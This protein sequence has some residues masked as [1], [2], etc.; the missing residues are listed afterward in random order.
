MT[1]YIDV[2]DEYGSRT[3]EVLL[4]K[5]IH[6]LGK[7]H[8]AVH[9]YLFDMQDNILLQR[10]TEQA[11]HYP[12]EMS[13]SLTGHIRSGEG[14]FAALKRELKEELNLDIQVLDIQFMFSFR[15]D[16]ILSANYIDKQFNDIYFC[17]NDF[18]LED[19]KFNSQEVSSLEL[20]PFT[21]FT[22][23]IQ[24]KDLPYKKAIED[25]LYFLN[26]ESS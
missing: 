7:V 10:R 26:F 15:Q 5:D 6:R 3:G 25:L 14:S 9:L 22:K 18:R 2:L 23:L 11:D 17:K 8:R 21:K 20:M 16:K 1:D 12:G 13:I 19:I 4:R 24:V